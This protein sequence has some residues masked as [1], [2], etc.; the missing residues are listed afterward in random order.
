[1]FYQKG[2]KYFALGKISI[3]QM[4]VIM[5]YFDNGMTHAE[6]TEFV[7]SVVYIVKLNID[8]RQGSNY[9]FGQPVSDC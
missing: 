9:N 2:Q 3:H 8:K 5:N 6:L 1:M 7:Y 4:Y